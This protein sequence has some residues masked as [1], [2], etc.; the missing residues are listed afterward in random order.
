MELL[1]IRNR[2]ERFCV[3]CPDSVIMFTTRRGRKPK[4]KD[5]HCEAVLQFS[6]EAVAADESR[7]HSDHESSDL[8]PR[9]DEYL[10]SHR[11]T[12]L[13]DR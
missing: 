12:P 2:F 11:L 1:S 7:S 3:N 5:N 8:N 13:Q 4:G 9:T 10:S 6:E